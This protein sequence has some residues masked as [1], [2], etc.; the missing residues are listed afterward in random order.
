MRLP[1]DIAHILGMSKRASRAE[2]RN[3]GFRGTVVRRTS[4]CT[5][6]ALLRG[7]NVGGSNTIS[8]TSLKLSFERLGLEDVRTFINSG[9]I[10]FRSAGS[11]ASALE[12][13]IDR[14]LARE[15]GLSSKAIVRTEAEM[16]RVVKT[17]AVR[18]KLD[19]RWKYNVMFLRRTIDS[20]RVLDGIALK[21]DIERVIYCPGTLLWSARLNGLSRTAMLKLVGQ[22]IYQEMT[23]RGVNTTTKI[24]ELMRRMRGV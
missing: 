14:V 21:P 13:R 5:Y 6:V 1:I 19:P 9:N 2:R 23:V 18:W 3:Y 24:L 15:H 16:A 4:S 12:R 20:P 11:N 17:I 7:V 22:P 8:M 10:L